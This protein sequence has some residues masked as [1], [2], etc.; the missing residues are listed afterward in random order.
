[1]KLIDRIRNFAATD[2][3][4]LLCLMVAYGCVAFEIP[5]VGIGLFSVVLCVLFVIEDDILLIITPLLMLCC[6][7]FL[8]T[9]QLFLLWLL[10]PLIGTL[11][12]R[13]I[14]NLRLAKQAGNFYSLSGLIAVTVAVTLSGLFVITPEEYFTPIPLVNMLCLGLFMIP[15]YFFFKGGMVSPRRY[16]VADKISA[17]MYILGIFLAFMILR[18]FIVYPELWDADN[19]GEA[20]S[21]YAW[22]RNGAATLVVMLFPFIF[23]YAIEHHPIHLL[24]VVLVYAAIVLS[25]SRGGLLCGGVE[26]LLCLGYYCYYKK[27][28]RRFV[29]IGL[30]VCAVVSLFFYRQIFEIGHHLLRVTLDFELLMQ[31]DRVLFAIRSID[32]FLKNPIFGVGFGYQGNYDIHVLHVNWYHSLLPQIVGGMGVVGIVAYAYQFAVRIR[33]MRAAPRTP[34]MGALILSYLGVLI[35]SQI[36]PGLV[37]PYAIVATVLFVLMEEESHPSPMLPLRKQHKEKQ[38]V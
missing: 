1:M 26:I 15:I 2:I 18:F 29:W 24:S 35:Y 11:A 12:Y 36:D 38:K 13:F 3:F 23:Y 27:A 20:L 8:C 37:S 7:A 33:L 9:E 14:R 21:Q 19:V 10:I 30:A 22:W 5:A 25:G 31:E 17:N 28:H 6:L 32:D 16:N 4:M 34:Y